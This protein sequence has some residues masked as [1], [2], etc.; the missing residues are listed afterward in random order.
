MNLLKIISKSTYTTILPITLLTL[1]TTKASYSQPKTN[2]TIKHLASVVTLLNNTLTNM[3]IKI[4][5]YNVIH[6]NTCS[7]PL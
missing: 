7:C 2:N 6:I 3:L 4:S 5:S 1:S